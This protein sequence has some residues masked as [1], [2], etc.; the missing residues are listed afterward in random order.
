MLPYSHFRIR[1][2]QSRPHPA[3]TQKSGISSQPGVLHGAFDAWQ[4]CW[5]LR[6]VSPVIILTRAG[7][8]PQPRIT[9]FSHNFQPL[10]YFFPREQ[11]LGVPLHLLFQGLQGFKLQ[12]SHNGFQNGCI[13]N[14]TPPQVTARISLTRCSL[15]LRTHKFQSSTCCPLIRDSLVVR[16]PPEL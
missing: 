5:R 12:D 4:V 9:T 2:I 13:N 10:I 8:S 15:H 3:E 11:C 14:H 16:L 1:I 7:H 6:L